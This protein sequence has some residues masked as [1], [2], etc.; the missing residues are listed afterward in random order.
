[1]LYYYLKA[2]LQSLPHVASL[3]EIVCKYLHAVRRCLHFM[4]F[5][6]AVL[7]HLTFVLGSRGT[8]QRLIHVK[9]RN[10]VMIGVAVLK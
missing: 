5:N 2:V 8:L 3:Y 7:C 9:F 4:R 6:M 1:M 10:F